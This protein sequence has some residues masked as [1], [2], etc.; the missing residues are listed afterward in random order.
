MQP[1]RVR[2]RHYRSVRARDTPPT[3]RSVMPWFTRAPYKHDRTTSVGRG[4][5]PTPPR[6][7]PAITALEDR[8]VPSFSFSNGLLTLNGDVFPLFPSNDLFEISRFRVGTE[9]SFLGFRAKI[10]GAVVFEDLMADVSQV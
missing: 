7:R 8:T 10:N 3:Q 1:D 5:K 9:L 4:P 6:F 2:P